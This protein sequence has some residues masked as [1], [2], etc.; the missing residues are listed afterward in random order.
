MSRRQQRHA[1]AEVDQKVA[2]EGSVEENCGDGDRLVKAKWVRRFPL[3]ISLACRGDC[4]S[5][6]F[7][8]AAMR[9]RPQNRLC[10]A[11]T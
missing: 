3:M 8:F 9:F 7:L 6:S 5:L 10:P 4:C 1:K 11:T 2:L